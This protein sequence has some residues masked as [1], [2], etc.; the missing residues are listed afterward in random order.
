M[1]DGLGRSVRRL[2]EYQFGVENAPASRAVLRALAEH[3]IQSA[4]RRP[5]Q[6]RRL[7]S[8]SFDCMVRYGG[9]AGDSRK[10]IYS[11]IPRPFD[12]LSPSWPWASSSLPLFDSVGILRAGC[13]LE[14]PTEGNEGNEGSNDRCFGV[15]EEFC[16]A[17]RLILLRDFALSS[18]GWLL[19]CR[20]TLS[21]GRLRVTSHSVR[22]KLNGNV[23]E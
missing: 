23:Y 6:P 14:K 2:A 22:S 9:V 13:R 11:L 18:R 5:V 15:P 16:R 10:P 4:G 21:A 8:P 20:H 3:T 7:R 12:P 1:R 19:P 17:P